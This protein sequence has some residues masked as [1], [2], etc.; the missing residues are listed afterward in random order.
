MS[1]N[2]TLSDEGTYQPNNIIQKNSL[3]SQVDMGDANKYVHTPS[4]IPPYHLFGASKHDYT[5]N[6]DELYDE[7][8]SPSHLQTN[9]K[10]GF[11]MI[12][13]Q[14]YRRHGLDAWNKESR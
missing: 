6:F 8:P 9:Y 7:S 1:P 2:I 11:D 10:C 5:T 12:S 3:T 13:K 14:G 4:R